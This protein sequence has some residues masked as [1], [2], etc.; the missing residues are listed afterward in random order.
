MKE[1][2]KLGFSTGRH[3]HCK[4]ESRPV[5]KYISLMFFP[6]SPL[7]C[8][9]VCCMKFPDFLFRRAFCTNGLLILLLN[10]KQQKMVEVVDQR[11]DP[12]LQKVQQKWPLFSF[13]SSASLP[14][15]RI[16]SSEDIMQLKAF[17]L[18]TWK[19]KLIFMTR[20]RS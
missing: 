17:L 4:E 9:V 18:S 10:D 2:R 16:F 14:Q 5:C 19:K 7:L 1:R 20:S 6:S 12:K 11:I 3:L 15:S 8:L 13:Q